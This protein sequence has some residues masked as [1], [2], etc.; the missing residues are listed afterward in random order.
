MVLDFAALRRDVGGNSHDES[1]HDMSLISTIEHLRDFDTAL[2][3]NTISTINATPAHTFYMDGSIRSMTPA[4]G[5]SVGVAVTCEMDS[6][7]PGSEYDLEPYWEQL[8]QI[9]R[10]TEPVIWVI[11]AVGSRPGHECVLGDG[12]AKILDSIGVVAAI[13]DGGVRDV[14]GLQTVGFAVYCRGP[15]IHHCAL[16]IR[17]VNRPVEIGG[18]TVE[19]GDVLHANDEGVIRIPPGC[20]DGLPDAAARMRAF[21]HDVHGTWRRRDLTVDQKRRLVVDMGRKHGFGEKLSL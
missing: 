17:S 5:P 10:M 4:L 2:L 6:S 20:L 7:S 12:M 13:T 15:V 21:E 16:R 8:E 19:P 3:A 1:M 11:K 9:E 18:I 14:R